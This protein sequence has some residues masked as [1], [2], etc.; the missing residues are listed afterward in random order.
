MAPGEGRRGHRLRVPAAAAGRCGWCGRCLP[1]TPPALLAARGD[2]YPK[3]AS[4]SPTPSLAHPRPHFTTR[5]PLPS[6]V[7]RDEL[8]EPGLLHG[9]PVEDVRRFHG[10][11]VVRDD[12][13]LGLARQLA[14]HPQE[15]VDVGV[16][17]RRVDL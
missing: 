10:L 2:D 17:E 7:D 14:E 16:V 13:E 11:A 9:H 12:E 1:G 6:Q 5:T 15:P 4:M 3:T 8:R